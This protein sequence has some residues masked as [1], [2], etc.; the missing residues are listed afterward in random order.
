MKRH[1]NTH[2]LQSCCTTSLHLKHPHILDTLLLNASD[3]SGGL[4]FGV[5]EESAMAVQTHPVCTAGNPLSWVCCA[6]SS[7]HS[8]SASS[9]SCLYLDLAELLPQGLGLS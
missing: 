3:V 6:C 2:F 8:G 5:H 7:K 4:S 9:Y 1:V